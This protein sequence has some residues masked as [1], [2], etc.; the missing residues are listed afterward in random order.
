MRLFRFLP[1]VL[2]SALC[3]LPAATQAAPVQASPE[4][5]A[6]DLRA[7]DARFLLD[8]MAFGTAEVR[9]GELALQRSKDPAVRQL[10]QT[11]VNDHQRANLELQQIASE[12]GVAAPRRPSSTQ[13]G[14]L[15][16]L[17]GVPVEA[18]DDQFLNRAGVHMHREAIGLF[19]ALV[20]LPDP[21]PD[22]KRFARSMLPVLEKHLRMAQAV[23]AHRDEGS[24]PATPP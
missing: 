5:A 16:A 6:V 17:R 24:A 2:L 11:M 9:A 15:A 1:G 3:A 19:H 21:D 22:L 13:R 8:A 12:K 10:A 23:S 20:L 18:F 7:A 14:M 4:L